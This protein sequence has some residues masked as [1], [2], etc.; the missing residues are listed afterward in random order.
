MKEKVEWLKTRPKRKALLIQ[1]PVYRLNVLRINELRISISSN[2]Q[3]SLLALSLASGPTTFHYF[4]SRISTNFNRFQH[5]VLWRATPV[6]EWW[7]EKSFWSPVLKEGSQSSLAFWSW[8]GHLIVGITS[9]QFLL[10]LVLGRELE[11]NLCLRWIRCVCRQ[12]TLIWALKSTIGKPIFDV[13]C[14]IL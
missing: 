10:E 9:P 11:R 4:P 2:N 12:A 6:H 5:I 13:T 7:D 14:L 8:C 1:E 3:T